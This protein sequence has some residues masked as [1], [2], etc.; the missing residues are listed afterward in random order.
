MVGRITGSALGLL[1]FAVA[2][3]AG[4]SVGN[5]VTVILSRS[6][7]ALFIFCFIG[8]VLGAAAQA[9]VNEHRRRREDASPTEN[10]TQASA[11]PDPGNSS[12][13]VESQPMGT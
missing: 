5:P 10:R 8:F 2:V 13:I 4:L 7:W 6:V 12:T 11:I 3:F 1:A 9:V